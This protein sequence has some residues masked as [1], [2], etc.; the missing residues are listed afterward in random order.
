[1]EGS[2]MSDQTESFSSP[3]QTESLVAISGRA[4]GTVLP[5]TDELTIGRDAD[6]TGRLGGDPT[7]SRLHARFTRGE[8]GP[9]VED[10]GSTNGT[11]VNG[12]RV[13]GRQQ[14]RPG[15]VVELGDSRLE[16]RGLPG[17]AAAPAVDFYGGGGLAEAPT[18]FDF[19]VVA[20]A[21]PPRSASRGP[22]EHATA[23]RERS[24]AQHGSATVKGE[25]RGIKERTER[26]GNNGSETIW[27]FRIERY[28]EAGDRMAPVAVQLRGY[29]FDGSLTEGDE[30]RV[31]G[32]WRDGTLH[33]DKVQNLTTRAVVKKRSFAKPLIAS[34]LVMVVFVV[35]FFVFSTFAGNAF[36][37]QTDRARE[38]FCEQASQ[39]GGSTPP[40]C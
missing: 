19:G 18:G 6:Q 40:G 13:S 29:G 2:P 5:I 7:L 11:F 21:E 23:P 10:L 20:P 31:S 16:V 15:D 4:T 32:K 27:T 34:L 17:A 38:S 28:D 9:V 25:I 36:Q 30:V 39:L 3:T 26:R 37:E 24:G 8:R 1:M 22:K 12:T 33:T 35:G 14:L